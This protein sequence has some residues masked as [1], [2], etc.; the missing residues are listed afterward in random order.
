MFEE[1]YPQENGYYHGEGI[2]EEKGHESHFTSEMN[3]EGIPN[4]IRKAMLVKSDILEKTIFE[5]LYEMPNFCCVRAKVP[6]YIL[7][8]WNIRT[9]GVPRK[10]FGGM[11]DDVIA[12]MARKGYVIVY[13]NKH[14]CLKV[15]GWERYPRYKI[16]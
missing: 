6:T 5:I 14:L 2:G 7:K 16:G 11:V 4:N 15:L 8:K 12:V 3:L 13:K 10:Q 1:V 9:R